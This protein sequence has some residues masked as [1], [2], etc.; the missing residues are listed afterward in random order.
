[1]QL[2]LNPQ[3]PSSVQFAMP[4]PFYREI[5]KPPAMFPSGLEGLFQD[6]YYTSFTG[7]PMESQPVATWPHV[8]R[9]GCRL[10]KETVLL[11][12]SM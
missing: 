1:M 8:Q 10:R 2:Q 6:L 5:P 9:R 11:C 12:T 4:S 7:T 3:D